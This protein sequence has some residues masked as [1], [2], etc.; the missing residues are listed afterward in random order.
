MK[1][2]YDIVLEIAG[3]TLILANLAK[4]FNEAKNL[5]R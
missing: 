5:N 2:L 4:D 1:N 3:H